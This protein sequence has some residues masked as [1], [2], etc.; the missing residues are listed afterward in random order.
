MMNEVVLR[1]VS[2]VL[3]AVSMTVGRGPAARAVAELAALSGADCVVDVGC[4]PGTALRRAARLGA[5]AC[6][7][8]PSPAMV[9]L[10]R[11]IT[12]A[13]RARNVTFVEGRAEALPLPDESATVVWALSSIH[14]WPD[15]AA[16]LAE[17]RRVLAGGGRILVAERLVPPGA[18]GHGAHGLTAD[19]AEQLARD[20]HDAGFDGVHSDTRAAGRRT[21]V[22]VQG[23]RPATR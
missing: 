1:S 19:Q 7:V 4:G 9:H 21:L 15:R 18:R 6:G 14:H 20:L 10:G 8:D 22:I 2:E 16:G 11:G 13:R 3:T 17:A 5:R 23:S 12:A